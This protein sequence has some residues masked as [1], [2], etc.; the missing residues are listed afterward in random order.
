MQAVQACFSGVVHELCMAVQACA[1]GFF[2]ELCMELCRGCM[3][4]L[5][6]SYRL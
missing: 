3:H 5:I 6:C 2:S 1:C 4:R